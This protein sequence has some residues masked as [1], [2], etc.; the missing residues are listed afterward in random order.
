[1]NKDIKMIVSLLED[2]GTPGTTSILS[3]A[4]M[5]QLAMDDDVAQIANGAES[6][7]QTPQDSDKYTA[8]ELRLAA[9]FVELVGGSE[10]A[11]DLIKKIKE[12][13]EVLDPDRQSAASDSQNIDAI[14]GL[15]PSD[16]DLPTGREQGSFKAM[17]NLSSLY[18][19]NAGMR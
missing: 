14:A 1:M 13:Q 12:V 17:A 19:P 5:A 4:S 3:G 2:I 16:V 15:V 9:R 6:Y 11:C 10:R 18:N 8:L 7:E